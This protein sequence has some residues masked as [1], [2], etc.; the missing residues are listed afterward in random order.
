MT[1]LRTVRA[2]ELTAAFSPQRKCKTVQFKSSP[3]NQ[4]VAPKKISG[5]KT[6]KPQ[7]FSLKGTKIDQWVKAGTG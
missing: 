2:A 5:L 7:G 6:Q 1:V 4:Q 3:R